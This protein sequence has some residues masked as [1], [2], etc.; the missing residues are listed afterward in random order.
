MN[1]LVSCSPSVNYNYTLSPSSLTLA[2]P[3]SRRNFCFLS[4]LPRSADCHWVAPSCQESQTEDCDSNTA[5]N[6]RMGFGLWA[7]G[8]VFGACSSAIPK[9]T[10]FVLLICLSYWQLYLQL[11]LKIDYS[12]LSI[13][14]RPPTVYDETLKRHSVATEAFVCQALAAG[15]C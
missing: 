1:V 2:A 12:M 7:R 14:S 8:C 6:I 10:I 4:S 3:I 13:W 11:T 15:Y 5:Q 9:P